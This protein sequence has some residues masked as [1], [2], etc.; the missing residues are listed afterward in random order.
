M[1]MLR[2][3]TTTQTNVHRRCIFKGTPNDIV[4]KA[5]L[6]LERIKKDFERRTKR[7]VRDVAPFFSSFCRE[8]FHCIRLNVQSDSLCCDFQVAE[9][10][11][12]VIKKE[13]EDETEKKGGPDVAATSV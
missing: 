5:G 9:V 1:N 8:R 3:N 2:L 13:K 12:T 6:R 11:A 7:R 10:L 4:N